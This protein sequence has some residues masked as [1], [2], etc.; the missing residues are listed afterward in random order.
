MSAVPHGVFYAEDLLC[1]PDEGMRHELV[2]GELR[3]M[4]PADA[5]HGYLAMR[6]AASLYGYVAEHRLGQVFA[7]ETGFNLTSNPD[8]VRAPDVA[9]INRTRLEQTNIPTGYWPGAPDLVVEVISPSDTYADVEDKVYDWLEAGTL[10]VIVV[11]P[12]KQ[13]VKVYRSA[14]QVRLLAGNEVLD[15]ADVVPGW[16]LPVSEIFG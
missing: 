2:R 1:Y 5:N 9:F 12:R 15:G 6:I 7:A 16:A 4:S 11:N 8:T 14:Q 3:T 10:L 13:A